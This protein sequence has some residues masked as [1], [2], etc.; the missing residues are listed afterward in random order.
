MAK[1]IITKEKMQ[2]YENVRT[3]GRTNMWAVDNVIALSSE[4]LTREDCMEIMKNYDK[5]MK[6]FKIER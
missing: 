1:A 3:E 5:Y 6:K 2:S 4:P